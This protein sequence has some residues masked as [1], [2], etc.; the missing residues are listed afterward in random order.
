MYLNHKFEGSELRDR[1]S[2]GAK[3]L[4]FMKNSFYLY[5]IIAKTKTQRFL[6][7]IF[8]SFT[9][10]IVIF[11]A[12]RQNST[13]LTSYHFE[14]HWPKDVRHIRALSKC[15]MPRAKPCL[16]VDGIYR[17]NNND[18]QNEKKNESTCIPSI[19]TLV[20][21]KFTH[22]PTFLVIYKTSKTNIVRPC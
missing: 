3:K 11:K 7:R 9:L 10:K 15:G 19:E 21:L 20:L 4:F 18:L 14:K 8:V 22:I 1:L 16:R 17:G 13:E 2:L 5:K 12:S 6:Q